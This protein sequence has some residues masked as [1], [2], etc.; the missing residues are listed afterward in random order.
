LPQV[1]AADAAFVVELAV[2]V[3]GGVERFFH[4]ADAAAGD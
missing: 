4:A 2:D 1:G 3:D